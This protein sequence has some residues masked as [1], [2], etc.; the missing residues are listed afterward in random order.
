MDPKSRLG[1]EQ[2]RAFIEGIRPGRTALI[3]FI[4]CSAAVGGMLFFVPRSEP[5]FM[6]QIGTG[7]VIVA[8]FL[9]LWVFL[10]QNTLKEKGLRSL[11]AI[12]EQKRQDMEQPRP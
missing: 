5:A 4:C 6:A 9:S 1:S 7:G 8:A 2:H 12:D 10:S 11:R 3:T